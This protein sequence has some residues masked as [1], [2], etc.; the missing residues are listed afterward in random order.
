[1]ISASSSF[2]SLSLFT[3]VLYTITFSSLQA[4]NPGV[5]ENKFFLVEVQSGLSFSWADLALAD[6][7]L[8]LEQEATF[9]N[10]FKAEVGIGLNY[11]LT[12]NLLAGFNLGTGFLTYDTEQRGT[13]N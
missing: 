13:D 11:S 2:L 7:S 12:P 6:N 5:F 10:A 4:Q 3:L 8:S 9:E 1:M